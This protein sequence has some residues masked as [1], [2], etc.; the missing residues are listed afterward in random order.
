MAGGKGGSQTT[1]VQIPDYLEIPIQENIAMAKDMAKIGYVPQYGPDVAGFSPMQ[2]AAF[3]NTNQAAQAF[4]LP[5]VGGS[6]TPGIDPYTGMRTLAPGEMGY[7]SGDVFDQSRAELARRRPGQYSALE[8]F[9]IDPNT[10][11]PSTVTQGGGGKGGGQVGEQRYATM[12]ARDEFA[13]T[14]SSAEE[15]KKKKA[16]QDALR[17][18]R[19]IGR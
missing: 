3:A 14:Q 1:E 15:E 12:G 8:S 17:R 10:P 18:E 6:Y 5:S 19:D 11:D 4:G 7:S 2:Q 13:K 16:A 9:F